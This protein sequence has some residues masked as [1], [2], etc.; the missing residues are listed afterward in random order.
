[1]SGRSIGMSGRRAAKN[2]RSLNVQTIKLRRGR[3]SSLAVALALAVTML[4]VYL[5]T[6]QPAPD[7][8]EAAAVS[9][10]HSSAEIRMEEMH[11]DFLVSSIHDDQTQANV[12]AAMCAQSG[13]AGFVLQKD[14][15]YAVIQEAG[16]DFSDADAPVIHQT[17][18]GLTIRTDAPADVVTAL[19]DGISALRAL[20]T[21]TSAL[22]NAVENGDTN[23]QSVTALLRVYQTRL[24]NAAGSLQNRESIPLAMIRSALLISLERTRETAEHPVP[25]KIRL[26][27]AA[28][29]LEWINLAGSLANLANA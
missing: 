14:G 20:A 6:L 12:A 9:A 23:G 11:A 25:G 2:C 19:S 13:G 7:E 29:C 18:S 28:A 17:A 27:H 4:I 21:E 1:M 10:Q 22:A 24:E 8:T 5:L 3:P 16:R 26:L 15:Q